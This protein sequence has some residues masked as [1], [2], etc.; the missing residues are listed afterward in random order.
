MRIAALALGLVIVA[1]ACASSGTAAG[2]QTA[3]A[4]ASTARTNV[5]TLQEISESKAATIP[6]LIRQLRPG[7]P[8]QF[9]VFV[10]SNPDPTALNRSPSSIREIQLLSRSEAQARWG[11]GVS[12][13]VLITPK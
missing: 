7:W 1:G 9:M 6:D 11:S 8:R 3:T 5:I 4:R 13:V 2:D 12:E 10:G